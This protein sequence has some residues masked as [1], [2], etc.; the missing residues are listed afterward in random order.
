M[1]QKVKITLD[2]KTVEGEKE[3]RNEMHFEV[4]KKTRSHTFIDRKKRAK[5]GY[6]KHKGK[7]D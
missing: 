3:I 4:Q 2:G 6:R 5:N 7:D 1:K